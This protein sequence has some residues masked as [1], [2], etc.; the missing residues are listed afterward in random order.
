MPGKVLLTHI[1]IKTMIMQGH[2]PLPPFRTFPY[3]L[4]SG[5]IEKIYLV[6][7]FPLRGNRLQGTIQKGRTVRQ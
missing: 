4:R 7:A 1:L 3:Q 5:I 2:L 6:I